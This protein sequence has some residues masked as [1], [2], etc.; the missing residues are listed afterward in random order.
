MSN[1]PFAIQPELTA[2]SIAY[3]NQKL[4]A[5]Q[6][7]PRVTVGRQ[8]F[9]YQKQ[10]LAEGFTIPNTLVGRKSAPTQVE[11]SATEAMDATL[12][13]GL[14]DL[15]P[16][17]DIQNAAF[18][19]DP[20]GRAVEGLTDLILLDRERRAANLVFNPAT[21]P[22]TNQTVL[23]GTSQFSD[24]TN[25]DPVGTLMNI[26]D[27]VVMRPNVM[28]MGRAVY[29]VLARHPKIVKAYNGSAGDSGIVPRNFLADLFE[30]DELLVG[31]AWL[32]TA[33]KGQP[34]ALSRVW[35][36]HI[37]VLCRNSLADSQRGTT[38]GFS[39]QFGTRVAGAS[40]DDSIGLRGGMRVRVG[41]S[42]KELVSAP[43]LGYLLQNAVA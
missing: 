29:S 38:F 36:K 19:Q 15:V 35:G 3:R 26:L 10:T 2:I 12:D 39:A 42:V 43:D 20:V 33:H 22:G 18:G 28:V 25:S 37:A 8:E 31:E 23:S 13:F 21:Y 16:Q 27:G 7:L 30:L 32:N 11:F 24:Y 4:I 40:A 9:K 17:A 1:A 6:V 5:D 34:I 41:E 14:D